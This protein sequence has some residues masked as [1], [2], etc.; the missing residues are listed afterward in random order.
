[1]E[2][3]PWHSNPY[4]CKRCLPNAEIYQHDLSN[5]ANSSPSQ[6]EAEVFMAGICEIEE[7]TVAIRSGL[8]GFAAKH[9]TAEI[10]AARSSLLSV[11][12]S[13]RTVGLVHCVSFETTKSAP[14]SST[15]RV[16][17]KPIANW[18]FSSELKGNCFISAK[19][20]SYEDVREKGCRC[21][22][23]GRRIVKA[24]KKHF[25]T[26]FGLWENGLKT[27]VFMFLLYSPSTYLQ[28]TLFGCCGNNETAWNILS[29]SKERI[30]RSRLGL[31]NWFHNEL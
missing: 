16:E 17:M 15:P 25:D 8:W 22:E 13:L 3:L 26:T 5:R 9:F 30:V 29:V 7:F 27:N 21:A 6:K 12:H 31:T 10:H 24:F 11:R 28:I 20:R 14:E 1:M 2:N 18:I 19:G 23:I 4:A